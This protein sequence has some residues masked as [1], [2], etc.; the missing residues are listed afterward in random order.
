MKMSIWPGKMVLA[1]EE[2]LI[3][4]N[5]KNNKVLMNTIYVFSLSNIPH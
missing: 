5:E 3:S 2:K 4:D 1:V